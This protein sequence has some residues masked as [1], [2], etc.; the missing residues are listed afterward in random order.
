MKRLIPAFS[1]LAVLSSAMAD[2]RLSLTTGFDYSTGK[3]GGTKSVDILYIPVTA[4]YEEDKLTLKLT[5]PYIRV[6]G[7]GAGVIPGLGRTGP[8]SNGRTPTTTSSGLG[9]VIASAGY[10][11]YNVNALRLDLVGK[12][13]LGTADPNKG[14][15]TGKND[16]SAEVDGYYVVRK[17]TFFA[18]AGYKIVGVPAGITL[19]NVAYGEIGASQ[20]LDDINS[21]GGMLDVAQ[22]PSPVGAGPETVTAFITHKLSD[23][24]KVQPYVLRGLSNGSPDFGFGAMIT[25]TF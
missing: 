7:A 12:V 5:V 17:T 22:S 18:T 16:Y 6:T 4:T 25:G 14:L 10:Q 20:K 2:D 24:T 15:G 1:L 21:V 23:T 9:D 11:I 13:K 8:A 3:Y 19:N